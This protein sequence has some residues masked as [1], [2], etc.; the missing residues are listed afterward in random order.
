M[1]A[2]PN[3]AGL[4][5]TKRFQLPALDFKFGSLT[6]GTDIPPPL[7]SPVAEVPTPPKTPTEEGVEPKPKPETN[8][9]ANGQ[10]NGHAD[11]A[12][13]STSESDL[14]QPP[15]P[16]QP[17]HSTEENP[18]SPTLSSRGS[19]RRLLS[20]S[21]LVQPNDDQAPVAPQASSRPPSRTAS[22]VAEEK[23]SKRSSGWFRRLRSSD[24]GNTNAQPNNRHSMHIVE[25]LNVKPSGP[26]PPMIPEMSKWE[27]KV[28]TTIGDDLFKGIR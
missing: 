27:T 14:A 2:S 21:L 8:D 5:D 10:T 24:H 12:D 16:Q 13:A 26:P 25:E 3:A 6:E 15:Q 18:S 23:K 22:V 17:Q 1:P 20:R 9:T 19:L 7:P 28:D 11:H 4:A